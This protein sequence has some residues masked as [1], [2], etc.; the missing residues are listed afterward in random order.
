MK[1]IV[2]SRSSSLQKEI[3]EIKDR[4]KNDYIIIA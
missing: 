4:L 3:S 2:L 1:K